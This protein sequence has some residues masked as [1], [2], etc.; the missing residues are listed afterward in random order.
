MKVLVTGGHGFVGAPTVKALQMREYDVA[1]PHHDQ[2]DLLNAND[3]QNIL[4]DTKPDV[5]VH[6]AWQTTHGT[7][8]AAPDNVL[9]RDSSIDLV[10]RFLDG[11]GRRAVMAGSCAEYDWTTKARLLSENARCAP[12]TLYGR[13]KLETFEACTHL[14]ED[15]A[16]IAW[17]RLFFLLGPAEGSSRFIPSILRPMLAGQKAKMGSGTAIRDFMH[18]Y[19]AGAAFAELVASPLNGA[20]NVASGDARPLAELARLAAKLVGTGKLDIGSLPDQPDEPAS[21][22]A[23]I[24]RLRQELNFHP[25]HTPETAIAD[26]VAYWRRKAFD[27]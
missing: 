8:W 16:S 14:I 18:T 10:T 3:R 13:C 19:D 26:C 5:L 23:D 22:A 11:G 1:V 24:T 6:L 12:A 15:G 7:F 25:M 27:S 17:G 9:W 21:L 20:V 2:Y 4:R